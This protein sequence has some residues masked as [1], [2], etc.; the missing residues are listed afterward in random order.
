MN[1]ETELNG[2]EI[3]ASCTFATGTPGDN[4]VIIKKRDY[5]TGMMYCYDS[6]DSSLI[7]RYTPMIGE[8]DDDELRRVT[9]DKL[10][11]K[12]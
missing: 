8:L 4:P 2:N 1:I 5:I 12:H 9:E 7:G 3:T 6:V 11:K 10:R